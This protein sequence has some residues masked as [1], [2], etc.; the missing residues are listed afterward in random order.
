MVKTY[1]EYILEHLQNITRAYT[2]FGEELCKR[3]LIDSDSLLELVEL[4][5]KSK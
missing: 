1:S 5:D 4:H 3:L 2:E